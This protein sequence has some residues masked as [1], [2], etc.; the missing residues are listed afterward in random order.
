MNIYQQSPN[1]NVLLATGCFCLLLFSVETCRTLNLLYFVEPPQFRS[2]SLC[3]LLVI[4]PGR[5][6]L[7][8]IVRPSLTFIH[9]YI[10]WCPSSVKELSSWLSAC[11]LTLCRLPFPF[12]PRRDK[13][14]K[15]SVLPAKT[16][17]SLGIRPVCSEYSLELSGQLRN[18]AFSMRTGLNT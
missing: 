8:V 4:V 5:C 1:K 15:M 12:G 17:I 11:C 14:N 3:H 7:I 13:I 9:F 18:Q 2:S 16:Q 10:T 6:F